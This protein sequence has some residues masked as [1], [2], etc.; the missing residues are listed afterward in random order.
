MIDNIEKL[1]SE[2]IDL[3]DSLGT[4]VEKNIKQCKVC[5]QLKERILAGKFDTKNKKWTNEQGKLWNG[6]T[7]PECHKNKTKTH[8]RVKR[9]KV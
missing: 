7:C 3:N 9:A 4:L 1:Q 6:H 8:L 5:G 2:Q